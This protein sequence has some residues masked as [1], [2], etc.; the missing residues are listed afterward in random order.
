MKADP[1][2]EY[3]TAAA[4]AVAV[5]RV[6]PPPPL[7]V[8][9]FLPAAIAALRDLAP[10][11]ARGVLFRSVPSGWSE[12]AKRLDCAVIGAD[13][14]RLRRR[15][16]GEI[17]AAGYPVAAYTVNDPARARLLFSWGVTSVFSDMPDMIL[18]AGAADNSTRPTLLAPPNAAR[19]DQG[20]VQ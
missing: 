16:V 18:R 1:G 8:S 19:L 10:Q 4:V 15:R 12:I 7:F 5:D 9:S 3:A 13:H 6:G 11:T 14:K 2:R 20:A 17:R